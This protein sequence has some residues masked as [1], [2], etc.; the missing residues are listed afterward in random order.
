VDGELRAVTAEELQALLRR[1]QQEGL[2]VERGGVIS[3]AGKLL[4]L[5]AGEME[6]YGVSSGTAATAGQV[7]ELMGLENPRV[8]ELEPSAADRAV[9]AITSS[10]FT[11]VLIM[12]GLVA[13]FLEITSPGFGIPGTV[14]VICFAVVFS[15]Y[16]LLG[17]VGSL[18]LILFVV[19]VVL[20][21]LELFVIPGFGVAGVSGI[22]LIV[23]SLV[24]SMQGFVVPGFH[25]ERELLRRNLLVVG[26]STVASLIM[27]GV[28][29]Y[30]LPQLRLFS[31]LTLSSVQETAQGYTVQAAEESA[32][33][34]GREGTAVTTLRPVG[35]AEIDGETVYVETEGEYVEP[36]ARVRVIEV[37]GNRV[38]VRKC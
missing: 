3:P 36:G 38:L 4:T 24:L 11:A 9:E 32:R 18:E 2:A 15:G 20:L 8:T 26:L 28:L 25:W 34:M 5:T 21:V 31:R 16:A 22:A 23:A 10:G 6:R 14:A 12:I 30:T 19:G 13:L 33:L 29:A 17:T 27:F 1:A 35:K 7:L 37:S